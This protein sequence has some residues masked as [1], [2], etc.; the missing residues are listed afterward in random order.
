MEKGKWR[1]KEGKKCKREGEKL[2]M[3]EGKSSKMSRGPFTFF[4]FFFSFKMMKICF[5]CT[6]MEISTQEKAFHA[7]K[8]SGKMTL[9]PQKKMTLPPQKNFPVM[10]LSPTFD[11]GYFKRQICQEKDYSVR[12]F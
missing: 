4:F 6:K 10:P 2:K 9:S 1:R 5:G 8:K 11:V 3:D 7:R 12:K